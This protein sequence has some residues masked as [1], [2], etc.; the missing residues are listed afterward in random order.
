MKLQLIDYLV[1]TFYLVIVSW[2]G[3]VLRKGS[4]VSKDDYLLGGKR[5]PWW[6]LGISNASGMF[7]VSG[8]LWMVSIMFVYG[9][10]SVWLPWLWP[11]FNQVFMFVYLASWIRKSEVTTGAEWMLFRFG[12]GA[13][14]V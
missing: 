8:T 7:D 14:A 4:R 3:V 13:E 1:I 9:L 6:M 2:I 12:G 10:K 5:L 11:V